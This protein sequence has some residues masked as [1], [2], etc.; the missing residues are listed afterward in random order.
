MEAAQ[1]AIEFI[2]TGPGGPYVKASKCRVCGHFGRETNRANRALYI[3]VEL[4]GDG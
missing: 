3:E 2:G 4:R 1:F